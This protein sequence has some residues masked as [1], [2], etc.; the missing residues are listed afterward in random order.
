MSMKKGLSLKEKIGNRVTHIIVV[1]LAIFVVAIGIVASSILISKTNSLVSAKTDSVV[2]GTT[3]W[4]QAQIARVNLITDTLTKADYI[5]ANWDRAEDY[6]AE[7]M[8]ENEAAYDY[9]FGMETKEC[10]FGS[11]WNPGPDGY[12]PTIRDWYKQAAAKE[13]V[14]VSEAYVDVDTGRIVITIAKAIKKDG[15]V[16]GVFAADFFTDEI[17]N[18][19]NNLSTRDNFAILVDSAGA[20]LTHQD[21]KYIPVADENGDMLAYTYSDLGISDKLFQPSEKQHDFSRDAIYS[22]EYIE[23]AGITVVF[24]TSILSYWGGILIFIVFCLLMVAIG[25]NISRSRLKR[26]LETLFAP[27]NELEQVAENMTQCVLDYNATYKNEDEIGTLCL[28]IEQSNQSMKSYIDDVSAK[29]ACMAEGDLTVNVEKNYIGSFV[30]LKD[31]INRI[32]E[33]LRGAMTVIADAADQVHG[34]SQDVADSAGGLEAKVLGVSDVVKDVTVAMNQIQESLAESL[35]V[36]EESMALS[37]T[38]KEYLSDTY[39]DMN[40]LLGAMNEISAKSKDIVEI[41]NIITNIA[42]ETNLLALN[43]SIEAARAGEAGR[44]FAVVADS[45]RQLAEQT[46]KAA[47]DTAVLIQQSSAAVERGNGLMQQTITRMDQLVEITENVNSHV[48]GIAHNMEQEN[49]NVMAVSDKIQEVQDFADNTKATSE[50]CVTLSKQLYEL[51]DLMHEK[52]A[53]FKV[54]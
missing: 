23:D 18:M 21:S 33:S 51:V 36:A 38:A 9:Y 46:S 22:S 25:V 26:S 24:K 45:V 19:V 7:C 34:N 11:G 30:S 1:G 10:V 53:E 15:K 37:D 40:Q 4:F 50:D 3:G 54:G 2:C 28:A 44:G 39:S 5:G 41:I 14:Y 6:L 31:S 29:L 17:T 27:M 52:I 47:T 42:S 12:D 13:G 43:A 32:S 49:V 16:V 48:A 20:V 35:S 8:Q